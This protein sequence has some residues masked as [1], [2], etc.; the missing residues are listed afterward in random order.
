M[1]SGS[2]KIHTLYYL[3]ICKFTTYSYSQNKIYWRIMKRP[4]TEYRHQQQQ[5]LSAHNHNNITS[6]KNAL[7]EQLNFRKHKVITLVNC[8]LQNSSGLCKGSITNSFNVSL[9][10]SRAPISSNVT[11][12]SLGGITSAKSLFSNSFS[13]TTSCIGQNNLRE[14]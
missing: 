10:F 12:I 6:G 14:D 4:V 8:P 11:P 2:Y 1:A 13:V 9:T 7:T 5:E 3:L